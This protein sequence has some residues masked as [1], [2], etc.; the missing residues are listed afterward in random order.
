MKK[1]VERARMK[2]AHGLWSDTR[3]EFNCYLKEHIERA[4]EE[5]R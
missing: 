2:N 1:N 4:H 3:N 5:K